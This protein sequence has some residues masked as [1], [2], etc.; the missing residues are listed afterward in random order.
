MLKN[1]RELG[2]GFKQ[3]TTESRLLPC[4]DLTHPLAQT[5]NLHR[6]PESLYACFCKWKR[7]QM[8]PN[9][10]QNFEETELGEETPDPLPPPAEP[11]HS[12]EGLCSE[13]RRLHGVKVSPDHVR[14]AL[15][16]SRGANKFGYMT[17]EA[18]RASSLAFNDENVG[19][20]TQLGNL[21]GNADRE[22]TA[23]SALMSGFTYL[24]QFI[25]HDITWDVS[26]S[27][28]ALTDARMVRNLRTPALDLDSV[29]GDGPLL[30][31]HLYT[32]PAPPAA[33]PT[34]IKL[35]LGVNRLTGKG[36]PSGTGGIQGLKQLTDF[37]VPRMS[38]GAAIA[39]IGDPRNDENLIIS[40]LHHAFLRFHN[41]VVD[42][43][44]RN[45]HSGDI[46]A[47]AK[48]LVTHHYQWAVVHDFLTQLC[49][50]ERVTKALENVKAEPGSP[51]R[52][53]VEFSVAAFRF[54]HSMVRDVYWVNLNYP[55]AT[56][57]RLFNAV[58]SNLPLPSDLVVDLNGF[59]D[60]GIEV[61]K[62]RA[63][64]IDSV[65]AN[66]LETIPGGK[67]M[68]AALATRN[69]RRGLAL[70]LPS[71]Q[72]AAKF[73]DI[74]PLKPEELLKDLAGAE[75]ALLTSNEALLNQTPL[76]YYILREASVLREGK[77]LGPLGA[78]IV[79]RTFARILKRHPSSYI[80]Q[81]GGFTP[82]LPRAKD[83]TFT[84]VDLLRF[85]GVLAPP[86]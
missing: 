57:E 66:K 73:F 2:S 36:G 22:T 75:V 5:S 39:V 58:R 68:M 54:G 17:P 60:T 10:N 53:P 84:F 3:M 56:L 25:A 32:F 13:A 23:D 45:N 35:R 15:W 78:H 24:G 8:D 65:M 42:W 16:R 19:L 12:T 76:W 46:F 77:G 7:S 86:P 82:C 40:Q 69:L 37:D 48:K 47:Q 41:A 29:Y 52:M 28:D 18:V 74:A 44:E 59:F 6:W 4:T 55:N 33:N 63:R 21:M 85:A 43:L 20:L 70:G 71:G 49:G 67:D 50:A 27:L 38:R 26:P 31:P 61:T 81:K 79:A 72:A 14:G 83:D 30:S 9:D 34:A 80:N 64:K 62:N 51:F 1:N 11:Q